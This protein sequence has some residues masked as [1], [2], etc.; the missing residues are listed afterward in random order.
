MEFYQAVELWRK[1]V[2]YEGVKIGLA[3]TSK[4]ETLDAFGLDIH[5]DDGLAIEQRRNEIS[6]AA[7]YFEDSLSQFLLDKA[8]L[9]GEVILRAAH[10]LLIG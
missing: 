6:D 4:F 3:L 7:A 9:P 2:A 5:S 1:D 10:A 8:M